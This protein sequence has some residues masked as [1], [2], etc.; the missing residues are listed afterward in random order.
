VN[1]VTV[2]GDIRTEQLALKRMKQKQTWTD[3]KQ[4]LQY[5]GMSDRFIINRRMRRNQVSDRY[6][7][8]FPSLFDFQVADVPAFILAPREFDFPGF[9][10]PSNHHYVGFMQQDAPA[11]HDE[12]W[13]LLL[14]TLKDRR[15]AGSRLVYCSFGTV[16]A[17]N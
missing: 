3:L 17:G 6:K 8:A 10:N 9:S 5:V 11:P 13:N 2:P 12:K 4:R 7:L 15:A 14:S 1:S 16:D